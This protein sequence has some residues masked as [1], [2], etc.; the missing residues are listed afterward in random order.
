MPAWVFVLVLG[1]ALLPA[2]V[3]PAFFRISNESLKVLAVSG[4]LLAAFAFQPGDYLR[5]GW[6]YQGA[7]FACLLVRDTTLIPG[8]DTARDIHLVR[9]LLA[10]AANAFGVA[11]CWRFGRAWAVAELP[12]TD[13]SR[14]RAYLAAG[15]LAVLF[16][17]GSLAIHVR[18]AVQG[19]P[20]AFVSI[21]SQ[22]G[23]LIGLCLIA[24]VLPTALALRGGR[25]AWPWIMLTASFL[26]WLV[27]DGFM[28]ATSVFPVSPL[29]RKTVG[30]SCRAVA[31]I[32]TLASAIAQ[33]R[34]TSGELLSA[35]SG[36]SGSENA[37]SS[38]H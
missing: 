35:S 16:G 29:L 25:L 6:F 22:V 19:D 14:L 34:V 1:A 10:A 18:A 5:R 26:G 38:Q 2:Y 32:F 20:A 27:Y 37:P 31:L 3:L 8:F 13:R 33:R 36:S 4:C 24:P 30:E 28:A 11:S 9:A 17:C 21:A 23:D 12:D 15:G 7:C